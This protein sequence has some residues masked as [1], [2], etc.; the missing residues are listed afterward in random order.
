MPC[1]CRTGCATQKCSCVGILKRPCDGTCSCDKSI[2]RNQG[3]AQADADRGGTKGKG[4]QRGRQGNSNTGGDPP[5]ADDME[6]GGEDLQLVLQQVNST[7]VSQND[8]PDTNGPTQEF[9]DSFVA[10]W[11]QHLNTG[12][13]EVLLSQEPAF[14]LTVV[15]L[16][17][18]REHLVGPAAVQRLLEMRTIAFSPTRSVGCRLGVDTIE[19]SVMGTYPRPAQPG[20]FKQNFLLL[21]RGGRWMVER[22]YMKDAGPQNS[23]ASP[24]ASLE[25]QRS[26]MW[27]ETTTRHPDG[28]VTCTRRLIDNQSGQ[29]QLG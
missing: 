15:H 24:I 3:G 10:A 6:V 5:P 21:L 16:Q 17:G 11:N 29:K 7:V 19:I 14:E 27:E 26:K 25:M 4:K 9:I 18:G 20:A 2:C 13:V 22:M 1:G 8:M 23:Q 12:T 28:T